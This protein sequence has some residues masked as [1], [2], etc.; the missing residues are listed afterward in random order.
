MQAVLIRM[1]KC[2][3]ALEV[4]VCLNKLSHY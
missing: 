4:I 2:G 1:Q 3:Q